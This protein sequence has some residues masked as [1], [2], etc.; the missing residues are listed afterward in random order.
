MKRRRVEAP[1]PTTQ[2]TGSPLSSDVSDSSDG[3]DDR[4]GSE[5]DG[6]GQGGHGH[7]HSHGPHHAQPPV[8][9][10]ATDRIGWLVRGLLDASG[11]LEDMPVEAALAWLKRRASSDTGAGTAL[12][13]CCTAHATAV[14]T[15]DAVASHPWRAAM[16]ARLSATAVLAVGSEAVSAD[17]TRALVA[18]LTSPIVPFQIECWRWLAAVAEGGKVNLGAVDSVVL[19]SA[20]WSSP[21]KHVHALAMQVWTTMARRQPAIVADA[22]L[23]TLALEESHADPRPLLDLFGTLWAAAPDGPDIS[24]AHLAWVE[25][26]ACHTERAV[27]TAAVEACVA[28]VRAA[29][30]RSPPQLSVVASVRQTATN[31]LQSNAV[32]TVQAGVDLWGSLLYGPCRAACSTSS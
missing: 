30:R 11:D 27:R 8:P 17:V 19:T 1:T 24:D 7:G 16:L 4:R 31:L 23:P 28:A 13:D 5:A 2:G 22:L 3:G 29:V 14:S 9:A 18:G 15:P 32:T 12:L 10:L 20:A 25:Q 21:S 6:H 26:Q